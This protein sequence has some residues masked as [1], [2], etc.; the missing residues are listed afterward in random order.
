[1]ENLMVGSDIFYSNDVIKQP[2]VEKKLY[3]TT[4]KDCQ[5]YVWAS[6]QM[7]L[8]PGRNN[9]LTHLKKNLSVFFQTS[10]TK[11]TFCDCIV[12]VYIN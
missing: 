2:K 4:K 10:K 5:K 3:K 11:M 6:L 7:F 12:L 1:M 9:L 8:I